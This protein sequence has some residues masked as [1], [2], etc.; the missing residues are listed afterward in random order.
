MG[1]RLFTTAVVTEP[2]SVL[3]VPV[4]RLRAVIAHDQTPSPT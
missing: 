2:G 3:V 4:E 1:E